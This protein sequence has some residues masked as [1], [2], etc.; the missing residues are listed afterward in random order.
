MIERELFEAELPAL[1]RFAAWLGLPRETVEGAG[2][3]TLVNLVLRE[4]RHGR[5][6]EPVH[7]DDLSTSARLP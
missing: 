3:W 6:R 5:T 2:R 1:R 7:V 4:I